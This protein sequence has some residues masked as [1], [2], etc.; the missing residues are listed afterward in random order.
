VTARWREPAAA[1]TTSPQGVDCGPAGQ[2]RAKTARLLPT[3]RSVPGTLLTP[4]GTLTRCGAGS[5]MTSV[6]DP[7]PSRLIASVTP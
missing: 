7:P 5:A 1:T 6:V 4:T 3:G 2:A